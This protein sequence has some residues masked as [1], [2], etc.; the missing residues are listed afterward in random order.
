MIASHPRAYARQQEILDPLP[1][2]PLLEEQPGAF[3]HA[4]PRRC[5]RE[6]WP[7]A[8]AANWSWNWPRATICHR[9]NP[10]C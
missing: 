5:W 9:P 1:Y 6:R 10:S 4:L 7:P 3:E 8:Y 2:L